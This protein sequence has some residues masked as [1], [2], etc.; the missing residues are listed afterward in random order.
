MTRDPSDSARA[1]ASRRNGSRSQGPRTAAGKARSAQ[2]ALRHGLRARRMVLLDDEDPAEFAAFA[3]SLRDELAPHGVL[4]ADLVARIVSAAWRAR[5][6]DRLEAALL[7]RH[8]ADEPGDSRTAVGQGLIRDGHGPRALE[9][10]L[11]YRGTV[12]AELFRSLGA[13]RLL[14]A[15]AHAMARAGAA[16][17]GPR[18][19]LPSP[20]DAAS[21]PPATKRTRETTSFQVPGPNAGCRRQRPS[22]NPT[23]RRPV[24]SCRRRRR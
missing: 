12:Q 14:Q 13:L 15:E 4:Q 22:P 24:W 11:R 8:L 2:N 7:G 9:T 17:I 19:G 1:L 5:R 3:A 21:P 16:G 20:S 10:L 23:R 6:A 18:T